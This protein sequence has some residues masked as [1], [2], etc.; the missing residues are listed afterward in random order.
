MLAADVPATEKASYEAT[1]Q[2]LEK[3][4][5]DLVNPKNYTLE[6]IKKFFAQMT[7]ALATLQKDNF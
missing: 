5:E 1:Y 4:V 3:Y 6:G 7:N 2:I